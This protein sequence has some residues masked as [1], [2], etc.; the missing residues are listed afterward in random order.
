MR[1]NFFKQLQNMTRKLLPKPAPPDPNDIV[2]IAAFLPIMRPHVDLLRSQL[3]AAGIVCMI[4]G[5][6]HTPADYVHIFVRR[7]DSA[8]ARALLKEIENS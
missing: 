2:S 6:W 1:E 8:D 3:E 7:A 4:T 5:D